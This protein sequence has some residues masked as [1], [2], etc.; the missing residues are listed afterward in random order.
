VHLSK[1]QHAW[2]YMS[3]AAKCYKSSQSQLS[4]TDSYCHSVYHMMHM[5]IEAYAVET[6]PSV[7]P[8]FCLSILFIMRKWLDSWASGHRWELVMPC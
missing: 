4:V 1:Y 6:C 3:N 2:Q 7:C 5:H 8:F